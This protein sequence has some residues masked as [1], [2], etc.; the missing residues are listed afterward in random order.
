MQG[1]CF[2]TAYINRRFF[3]LQ[4]DWIYLVLKYFYLLLKI[5]ER[6]HTGEKPYLCPVCAKGFKRKE[7]LDNHAVTHMDVSKVSFEANI[8]VGIV[9]N[10]NFYILTQTHSLLKYYYHFYCR[11]SNASHVELASSP[12]NT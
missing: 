3:G 5:H 12:S 10:C 4:F 11:I 2:G 9:G 1:K 8:C 6:R 7:A